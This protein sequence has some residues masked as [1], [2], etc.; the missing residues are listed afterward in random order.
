M[1]S[2][3]SCCNSRYPCFKYWIFVGSSGCPAVNFVIEPGESA[4]GGLDH[5]GIQVA[6]DE[7]LNSLSERM[8]E[9]GQPF[10]DIE[11]TTCCYAKMEKSWVK[12][13][14]EE[15]WE[16]F[17]THSHDAEEYGEDREHL[18]ASM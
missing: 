2:R 3:I 9:S 5:L 4:H 6:S 8:R 10:L 14:N 11:K 16:A 7:E 1:V 15:K 13:P 17:I 12:G 18:L